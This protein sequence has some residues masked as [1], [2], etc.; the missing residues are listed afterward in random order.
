MATANGYSSIHFVRISQLLNLSHLPTFLLTAPPT[1]ERYQALA[2]LVRA[3][4]LTYCTDPDYDV[5]AEIANDEN[6]R[7][8]Y[9]GYLKFLEKDLKMS[10]M[11]T[12]PDNDRKENLSQGL[13][14]SNGVVVSRR[15]VRKRQQ[16]IAKHM[17]ARGKVTN[18]HPFPP[19]SFEANR[20][21]QKNSVEYN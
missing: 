11:Q 5:N 19:L 21:H 18:A 14:E 2:P 10:S 20:E 4:L 16:V 6:V 7:T 3:E 1:A 12:P 17:I 8:T 15:T 9:R 13:H